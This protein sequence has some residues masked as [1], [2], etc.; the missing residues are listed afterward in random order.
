MVNRRVPKPRWLLTGVVFAA[1]PARTV[2]HARER[3][4]AAALDLVQAALLT[5][6]PTAEASRTPVRPEVV[7]ILHALSLQLPVTPEAD[8][9]ALVDAAARAIRAATAGRR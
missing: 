3:F 6:G 5:R 7:D 8:R 1:V 9:S 2:P 4:L